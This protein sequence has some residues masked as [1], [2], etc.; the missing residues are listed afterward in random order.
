M[1][2]RN[3]SLHQTWLSYH[4]RS[5][6]K[7]FCYILLF[8]PVWLEKRCRSRTHEHTAAIIIGKLDSRSAVKV[9]ALNWVSMRVRSSGRT[10]CATDYS[11]IILDVSISSCKINKRKTVNETNLFIKV[12]V[13][14]QENLC[15]AEFII[16]LHERLKFSMWTSHA[17][18][19]KSI[20]FLRSDKK[21]TYKLKF[22]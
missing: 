15:H 17:H 12:F 18:A 6:N 20:K 1:F 5:L 11:V 13:F 16:I 22:D 14:I 10:Q 4:L 8:A 3:F 2:I 7:L 21:M 9:C 19:S